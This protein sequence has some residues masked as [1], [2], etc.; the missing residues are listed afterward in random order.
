MAEVLLVFGIQYVASTLGA[1]TMRAINAVR[2]ML[3][4]VGTNS[5]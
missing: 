3:N 5:W 2:C 1:G 4:N